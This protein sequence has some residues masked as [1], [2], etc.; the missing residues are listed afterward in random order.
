M[1]ASA[2]PSRDG[3]RRSQIIGGLCDYFFKPLPLK[4][5]GLV[6]GRYPSLGCQGGGGVVVAIPFAS[7]R[8]EERW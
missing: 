3:R 1:L 5:G 4:G 8:K 2:I 7:S 6:V